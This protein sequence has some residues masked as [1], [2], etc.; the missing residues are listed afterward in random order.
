MYEYSSF[1]DEVS[2]L[3]ENM[4]RVVWQAMTSMGFDNSKG[5]KLY[6]YQVEYCYLI[7]SIE[8]DSRFIALKKIPKTKELISNLRKECVKAKEDSKDN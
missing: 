8:R 3:K 1:E 5:T 2:T 6:D 7:D 4:K